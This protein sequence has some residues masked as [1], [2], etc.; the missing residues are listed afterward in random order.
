[1]MPGFARSLLSFPRETT[2]P[3]RLFQAFVPL[4]TDSQDMDNKGKQL[5]HVRQK[6][7]RILSRSRHQKR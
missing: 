2:P 1:M 3:L 7:D 4:D 5:M 6:E